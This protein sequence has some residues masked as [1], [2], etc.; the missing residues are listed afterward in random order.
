MNSI[1]DTIIETTFEELE[2]I[3][4]PLGLSGLI[5]DYHG[6]KYKF[7]LKIIEDSDKLIALGSGNLGKNSDW[8]RTRPRFNRWSWDFG[9]S[10]INYD[11]PTLY[12]NDD[13]LAA[14]CVGTK[15]LWYL[16]DIATI[17]EIISNK[18][19]IKRNNLL[20]SGSSAGGF[21]S[22]MLATLLKGS[23]AIA[24]IP[25]FDITRWGNHWAFIKK[26]CFDDDGEEKLMQEYGYRL[27]VVELIKREK[28]IP[29]AFIIFGISDI[30][31]I[32]KQTNPFLSK[33][34][35]LPFFKESN[36]I[37]FYFHGKTTGHNVLMKDEFFKVFDEIRSII[38]KD[39]KYETAPSFENNV[40]PD[41]P[42]ENSD[43]KTNMLTNETPNENVPGIFVTSKTYHV[44][45]S[46]YSDSM[47]ADT[48][49]RYFWDENEGNQLEYLPY[50]YMFKMTFGANSRFLQ[51]SSVD[52]ML[53]LKEYLGKTI[54]FSA[55]VKPT[56]KVRLSVHY[57]IDNKYTN[58]YG[59]YTPKEGILT[60][61]TTIPANASRIMF[62]LNGIASE[63]EN[64]VYT[65]D[66]NVVVSE[67]CNADDAYFDV[68]D[69]DS[70]ERYIYYPQDSNIL[71][72]LPNEKSFKFTYGD[73]HRHL[74]MATSDKTLDIKDYRGKKVTFKA[75]VN[76]SD[77]VRLG[78][79][80]KS[81]GKYVNKVTGYTPKER[82]LS[83]TTD[84]PD[85]AKNVVFRISGD[86]S[87]SGHTV[88]TK[89]WLIYTSD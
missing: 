52:K 58:L 60:L 16:E 20:F 23:I 73:A 15:D 21:A 80:Y 89:D 70:T 19:E 65:K 25:Q 22:L 34:C 64:I 67:L 81:D 33:L 56:Q 30:G 66:W 62:R 14:W 31:G 28:Y 5:V 61:E 39:S 77:K 43:I 83:L 41:D 88:Y 59:K 1:T 32:R 54:R 87:S 37:K 13:I 53:N 9:E 3:D 49:D 2:D 36:S 79:H 17:I 42:D 7:L 38:Y 84:I 74:Q 45:N 11:D 44:V 85:D 86:G 47:G 10:T 71:E 57:Q 27:K 82:I 48:R 8:D 4:L 51:I 63:E 76:P 40:F 46:L 68:M 75:Y 29:N 72:Y 55:Y 24:E 12:V 35:A 6:I 26:H 69:S 18:L 50:N 78:I